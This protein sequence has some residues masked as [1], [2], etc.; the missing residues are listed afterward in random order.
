MSK[1]K[2]RE[3]Y[4]WRRGKRIAVVSITDDAPAKAK[5]Q[6]GLYAQVLLKEAAAIAKTVKSAQH[7]FVW[8][9]LLHLAWREGSK[10]FQVSNTALTEYGISRWIKYRALL[11]LEAV[12]FIALKRDGKEALTVTI[13]KGTIQSNL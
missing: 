7:L 1:R 11:A 3:G 5:W 9:W 13:L 4:R 2:I 8:V 6:G 10:T 12:G